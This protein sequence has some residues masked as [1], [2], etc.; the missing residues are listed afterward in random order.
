M[1]DRGDFLAGVIIGGLVGG[2]IGLLLAP[3]SGEETRRRVGERIADAADAA[4]ERISE[5]GGQLK[6]RVQQRIRPDA[7]AEQEAA[8]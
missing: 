6:E 2:L 7:G 5:V 1:G 8:G 4:R 3:S